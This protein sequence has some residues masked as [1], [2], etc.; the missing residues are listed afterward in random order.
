MKLYGAI[1]I[2]LFL[3]PYAAGVYKG[4]GVMF[5]AIFKGVSPNLCM[6]FVAILTAVYLVLGGY[7]AT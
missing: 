7:V 6:L 3:V 5:S 4:L 1:I 2:F